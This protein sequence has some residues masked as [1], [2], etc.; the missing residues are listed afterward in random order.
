MYKNV[1][2]N[3]LS[4]PRGYPE[5]SYSETQESHG[6]S[7]PT[8]SHW[9]Y[10]SRTARP[11]AMAAFSPS[12][13]SK[14]LRLRIR[15]RLECTRTSIIAFADERRLRR[16]FQIK[17]NSLQVHTPTCLRKPGGPGVVGAGRLLPTVPRCNASDVNTVPAVSWPFAPFALQILQTPL[18][19]AFVG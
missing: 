3:K 9:S 13:M 14:R 19:N 8:P 4:L 16:L 2:Y 12:S 17:S 5:L 18:A 15:R 1:V 10:M 11:S 7:R 6:T